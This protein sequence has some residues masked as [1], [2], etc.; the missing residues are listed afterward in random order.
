MGISALSGC[1]FRDKEGEVSEGE[2]GLEVGC[3]GCVYQASRLKP[4]L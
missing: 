1:G 3:S 4:R 2:L